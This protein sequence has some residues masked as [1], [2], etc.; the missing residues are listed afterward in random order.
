MPVA[1]KGCIL[2]YV[3]VPVSY[4]TTV[5]NAPGVE[6]DHPTSFSWLRGWLAGGYAGFRSCPSS[7][8]EVSEAHVLR[9][10]AAG[11]WLMSSAR[12]QQGIVPR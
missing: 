7:A 11:L 6:H 12:M 8:E 4:T 1:A 3:A 9:L 5:L 2:S 10:H